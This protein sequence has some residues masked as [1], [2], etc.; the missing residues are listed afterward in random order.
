[1]PK[2]FLL[3]ETID[4]YLAAHN[5]PLDPI[6]QALIQATQQLGSVARMQIAPEQGAFIT[7]LAQLLQPKFSVEIGT[8]TGYSALCIARG[9]PVS[10]KLL[11]CDINEEWT[12]L[13]RQHW[14][15]AGVASKIDLR[16]APALETLRRLPQEPHIDFA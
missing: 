15:R 3:N 8:F 14:E 13:A 5:P 16:L 9:M 1:M 2:S 10:A 6:Q 12:A 7:W 4:A 11:C